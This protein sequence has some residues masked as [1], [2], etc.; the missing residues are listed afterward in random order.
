M[1]VL[2]YKKEAEATDKNYKFV[3]HNVIS[4]SEHSRNLVFNVILI[5]GLNPQAS[6]WRIEKSLL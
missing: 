5:I 6:I 1:H 3:Y 4:P 2:A